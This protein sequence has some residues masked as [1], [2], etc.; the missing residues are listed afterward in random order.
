MIIRRYLLIELRSFWWLLF[1]FLHQILEHAKTILLDAIVYIL[2]YLI[3]Y[4]IFLILSEISTSFRLSC[5]LSSRNS[6][7]HHCFVVFLHNDKLTESFTYICTH[8]TPCFFLKFCQNFTIKIVIK[9]DWGFD[10]ISIRNFDLLKHD[11]SSCFSFFF[12]NSKWTTIVSKWTINF[13]N[14]PRKHSTFVIFRLA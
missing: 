5:L 6:I 4:K 10:C 1:Y 8:Q 3:C 14:E 12:T 7:L 11:S 13:L 2:F 9:S